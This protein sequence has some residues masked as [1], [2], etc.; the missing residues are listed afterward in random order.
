MIRH[1]STNPMT[2]AL[3][4]VWIAFTPNFADTTLERNSFNFT[5]KEPIR[6]DEAKFSAAS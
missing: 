1:T 6:I 5:G 3:T 2:P 4:V